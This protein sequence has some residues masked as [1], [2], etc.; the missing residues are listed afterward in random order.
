MKDVEE[1][2]PKLGHDTGHGHSHDH[3][4]GAHAEIVALGTVTIGGST[5]MVD[6]DGQIEAGLSTEFGVEHIGGP[7]VAPSEAWLANPDGTKI[8]DPVK[9]EGHDSHWHFNVEPLDPVKKS[10][11]VLKVGTEEAAIDWHRGAAPKNGGILSIF[12]SAEAPAARFY[13]ELKLHDDAGDLE[14][15]L[16]QGPGIGLKGVEMKPFDVP[17]ETVMKLAF[18][19]HEGKTV[20]LRVRNGEENEDE[21]GK[22]NMRNGATNYFV[23]PG[24]SGQDPEWL[25]GEKWR[26]HVAVAFEV[27]GKAFACDQFVL[28]PHGAL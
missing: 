19:S 27:E 4:E 5:F 8:C 21:D 22:P 2:K 26:G 23:F 1:K 3:D 18:P 17:K 24:E 12:K 10:K 15:W 25:M 28:V 16:Y 7:K 20:E 13:L 6:R 11:F 14:L 9:G